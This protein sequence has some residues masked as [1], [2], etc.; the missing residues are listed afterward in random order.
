MNENTSQFGLFMM[1][2]FLAMV[3]M[4]SLMVTMFL[5]GWHMPGIDPYSTSILV[6]LL[7]C[8]VFLA[9]VMTLMFIFV[10]VR[11][12]LPRFR[13]DQL[14]DFGWKVLIPVG[15]VNIAIT[16]IIGVI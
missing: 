15:L 6:G 5:G 4:S 16:G 10:W 13:Y 12:S 8:V 11:W 2:E 3:T 1:G 14:M 7:T 9:K